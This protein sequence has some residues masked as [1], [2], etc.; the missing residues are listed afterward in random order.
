MPTIAVIG[1]VVADAVLPPDGLAGGS[2]TLTVH[3]GGG[4]ANTAVTLARLGTTA[5]FAG[6][7][8]G[9][10][11]G[12]LCRAKLEE[13]GVDLS[14][15]E[16]AT[17][18]ATLA[19]ARLDA[20]GAASYEFYTDGTADWAWTN[21]SLAPVLDGP[22][23]SGELPVAVHTGSLALALPPSGG[24]IEALLGRAR[25]SRPA[26]TVSIDPNL[27]PLLVPVDAYRAVIDR[28]A[29]LADIVRLSGD[30][31]ELLWPGWTPER[32]A[33]HLHRQGVPLAVVSLGGDGAFASLRG[34]RVTV[35]T[36]P[37]QLVDT[38]GAG[39]SFH[40]GLLHALARQGRLGAGFADLDADGLTAALQ[41]ASRVAAITCS[42][43]GADPPWAAELA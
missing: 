4:P 8:S 12:S 42:R 2:A 30:D 6:R 37:T 5:R 29:A 23:P 15:S 9:G 31:L 34:E 24:V 32:A 10:A 27:R 40:G 21:E 20:G 25:T 1:E 35:P 11:L 33:A 43:P 17:E 22:F 26:P 36:A 13:S 28:W 39:D 19:I 7:L 38:V 16:T 14:A 41:F 18:P 3:P